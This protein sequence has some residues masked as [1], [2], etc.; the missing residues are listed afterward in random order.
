MKQIIENYLIFTKKSDFTSDLLKYFY[1]RLGIFLSLDLHNP[2]KL[3]FTS[4]LKQIGE[5]HGEVLDYYGSAFYSENNNTVVFYTPKWD[6]KNELFRYNLTDIKEELKEELD[7]LGLRL[8]DFRYIIPLSDIYHELTHTIQ[9]QFGQYEFDDLLEGTNEMMTYFITGQWN[10]EYIKET[11][12]LWYIFKY[13]LKL[14]KDQLYTFVRNCIV[15]KD[16]DQRYFLSNRNFINTLS[17]Y[18]K[19]NFKYFITRYKID[20]YQSYYEDYKVEF[21]KDLETVH[22]LIFYKY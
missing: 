6:T 14:T 13:E 15:K 10:I 21:E 8:S 4:N 9:Y 5:V 11:F 18:Y 1:Q 17:K 19:G 22:N 20:Y 12:S 2:P 7:D 3:V 16:F